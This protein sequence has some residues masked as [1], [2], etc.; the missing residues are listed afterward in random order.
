MCVPGR[1]ERTRDSALRGK[2]PVRKPGH[3]E[4][5]QDRQNKGGGYGPGR[6]AVQHLSE[7][8]SLDVLDQMK[9]AVA[10]KKWALPKRSPATG[11]AAEADD[12]AQSD[13]NAEEDLGPR[14]DSPV[15]GDR[16]D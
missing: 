14:A 1:G 7:E 6:E 10:V 8:I 16:W 3:G 9:A 15:E 11:D 2:G 4:V 13:E 12:E 5:Q